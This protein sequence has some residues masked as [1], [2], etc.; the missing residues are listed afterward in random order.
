MKEHNVL[1]T[2]SVFVLM[3][4]TGNAVGAS[5]HFHLRTGTNAVTTCYL[6]IR[7]CDNRR[8]PGT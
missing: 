7:L 4:V 2:G 5:Q 8:S 6:L 1:G 3:S